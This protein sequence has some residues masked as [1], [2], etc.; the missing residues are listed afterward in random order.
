L[1]PG[2][3][4]FQVQAAN[5][6]GIWSTESARVSV[7][8]KPPWW[9]T[10]WFRVFALV[11][12]VGIVVYAYKR[13]IRRIAERNREL[14][15]L[16]AERTEELEQQTEALGS[17][18]DELEAT[19]GQLRTAQTQ[20]V[21]AEKLA[22][23]GRMT[24][25]VAHEIKNPLNFV[26]NFAQLS[27][28]L[29]EELRTE[30][31]SAA[32]RPVGEVMDEVEPLLADLALNAARIA[33]HGRRAD[34]IVKSMLLHAR[35]TSGDP[36]PTSL[37]TLLEESINL[38]VHG[39][40]AGGEGMPINIERDYD[41]RIGEVTIVR[42][43][44]GR[45]IMNLLDNAVYAT[46]ERASSEPGYTPTVVVRTADA[47]DDVRIEVE[48]NGPGIPKEVRVR[49]FEPFFTTKPTGEGTGLGL[50]LV[51][52]IIHSHRGEISVQ[53]TPGEGTTFTILLPKRREAIEGAD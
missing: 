1:T 14:E 16:V 5:S 2:R 25:G 32:D 39:S 27:E 52:D 12:I 3:Y 40:G 47:G 44:I 37:R 19:L 26:N 6:D 28:E 33:E 11:S 35:G 29:T 7:R 15:A 24:A 22:S 53:S 10:W 46:R 42:Q 8:I 17:K 38:V 34:G 41:E 43:A 9:Q 20:L 45:V 48:D 50:S 30:L 31:A 23:L 36:E 18:N 13:R 21:Q 51:H 4:V 49:L